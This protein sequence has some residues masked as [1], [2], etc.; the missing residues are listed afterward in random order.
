[1]V[2]GSR[3][4]R[5]GGN[6]TEQKLSVLADY[7]QQYNVALQNQ[8]F[9]RAYI[10]AFA[11]TGYRHLRGA[12]SR[13]VANQMRIDFPDLAAEDA[14]AFRDG[15]AR[16]A[17]RTSPP[18]HRYIFIERN[19]EW[20]AQL[21]GLKSDFPELADRIDI[22]RG[23]ANEKIQELCRKNW[24]VRGSER[25]AVLFLDPYGM[26]VEW[27]TVKAV[28]RTEAIDLWLLFPLGIGVN[29]LVT[30]TGD[31][32]VGWQRCLTKL[33]GTEEWRQEFYRE[34]TEH[35]LLGPKQV[36]EKVNVESIGRYF[37]QRLQSVF[38]GVADEPLVLRNSTGCPLY[39]LCFAAGNPKGARPA[40]R[41]ASHLLNCAA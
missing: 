21:A 11:G 12:A 4:H 18:F 2:T 41:I 6:W 32:P 13:E 3:L 1:M 14:Q 20:C 9:R 30:N 10:D 7:L 17:L 25:R 5:F 22:Q 40:L 37:N 33:L 15:S 16:L 34:R 24:H 36:M 31:I 8:P 28:A 39:L 23:D 38:A 29:R 19:V 26:Q 27:D 35:D